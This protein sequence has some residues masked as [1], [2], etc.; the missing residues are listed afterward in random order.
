MTAPEVEI[1]W[2]MSH[3]DQ[4]NN[5]RTVEVLE[6]AENAQLINLGVELGL[7]GKE[8]HKQH[9]DWQSETCHMQWDIVERNL[10]SVQVN[11][12][13]QPEVDRVVVVAALHRLHLVEK[14]LEVVGDS[15]GEH[16]RT[17]IRYS[18]CGSCYRDMVAD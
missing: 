7:E 3:K 9:V 12:T 18:P 8:N 5:N 15:S 2:A 17:L 14:G 11:R 10:H 1:R 6:A 13:A 16:V 4:D